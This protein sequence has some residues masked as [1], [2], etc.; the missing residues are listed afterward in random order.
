[1]WESWRFFQETKK[2][3]YVT[4]VFVSCRTKRTLF[5]FFISDKFLETKEIETNQ[6]LRLLADRGEFTDNCN[7]AIIG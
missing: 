5:R 3:R 6:L 7:K 4:E 1:M 2:N